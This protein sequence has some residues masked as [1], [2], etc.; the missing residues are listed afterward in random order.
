MLRK[1]SVLKSFPSVKT[2]SFNFISYEASTLETPS[3]ESVKVFSQKTFIYV[4]HLSQKTIIWNNNILERVHLHIRHVKVHVYY[5]AAKTSDNNFFWHTTVL[6]TM[7]WFLY[8]M[9]KNL[10]INQ[11][12]LYKRNKTHWNCTVPS[13]HWLFSCESIPHHCLSLAVNNITIIK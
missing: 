6:K 4:E 11:W 3:K 7:M 1:L 13:H 5:L 8:W 10:F 12:L 2:Y 9:Q